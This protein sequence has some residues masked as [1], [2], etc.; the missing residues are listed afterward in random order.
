MVLV[1]FFALV[2]YVVYLCYPPIVDFAPT[3]PDS[4]QLNIT[5]LN[6][7]FQNVVGKELGKTLKKN[8]SP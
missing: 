1:C 3:P 7:T 5:P 8:S 4:H 6:V 2:N